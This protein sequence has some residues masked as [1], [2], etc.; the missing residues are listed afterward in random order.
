MLVAGKKQKSLH[1]SRLDC[2]GSSLVTCSTEVKSEAVL[3][4]SLTLYR[5]WFVLSP[6]FEREKM[7]LQPS[8]DWRK[9]FR[10]AY[11]IGKPLHIWLLVLIASADLF[12]RVSEILA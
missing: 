3:A 11:S 6:Y 5:W 1:G 7:N 8:P 10:A 4:D 12:V 9:R 2:P